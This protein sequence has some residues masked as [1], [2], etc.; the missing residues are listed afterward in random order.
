M[1]NNNLG[2]CSVQLLYSDL[3]FSCRS[4][5]F[6]V[7]YDALRPLRAVAQAFMPQQLL[8][9]EGL[10]IQV[11]ASMAKCLRFMDFSSYED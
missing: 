11:A 2:A 6:S 1:G 5:G 3:G 10:D 8:P 9:T 7:L 4:L